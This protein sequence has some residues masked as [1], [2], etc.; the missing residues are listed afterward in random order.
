M[1]PQ[2]EI[3]K[4][5]LAT[6]F[7]IENNSWFLGILDFCEILWICVHINAHTHT[8]TLTTEFYVWHKNMNVTT[9]EC[10]Q[11]CARMNACKSVH[12]CM[13]TLL[14]TNSHKHIHNTIQLMTQTHECTHTC[15]CLC[16]CTNVLKTSMYT[17]QRLHQLRAQGALSCWH[18]CE[19]TH[20]CT[21]M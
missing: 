17:H 3:L 7:T 9:H 19:C 16:V 10:T 15:A 11:T 18:M 14:H 6:T 21:L 5:Q 1:P 12:E 20:T 13:C 4:G 2:A 8:Y